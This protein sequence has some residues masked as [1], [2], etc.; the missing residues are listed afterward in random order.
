MDVVSYCVDA[1]RLIK[2]L[3]DSQIQDIRFELELVGRQG[4]KTASSI[5]R[6]RFAGIPE[7]SFSGLEAIA[8]MYCFWQRIDSSVD[9][10]ADFWKEYLLAIDHNTGL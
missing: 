5:K 10:G 2:G 6:F 8:W 9:L 1:L 7:R 4:F 3:E